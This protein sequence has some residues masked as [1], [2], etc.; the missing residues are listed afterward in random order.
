M[1]FPLQ[2][3]VTLYLGCAAADATAE[4]PQQAGD[5]SDHWVR[6]TLTIARVR[7]QF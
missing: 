3:A 6:I 4:M 1:A 2:L 7:L 5:A